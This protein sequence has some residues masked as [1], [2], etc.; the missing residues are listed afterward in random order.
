MKLT[1]DILRLV[2]QMAEFNHECWYKERTLQGWK[3]G[4]KRDEDR[5]ENPCLVPY[6]ELSEEEKK[7]NRATALE[8]LRNI[9]DLGYNMM[10][11]E[12]QAVTADTDA[13]SR[14]QEAIN[15]IRKNPKLTVADLRR[16]WEQHSPALWAEN[17]DIYRR[18]VDAALRLGEAFLAFDITAEGLLVFRNDLRLTQ[19]QALALAR[20]GA[21]RRANSM[22][23]QLRLSGHQDEETLGILARTH[24]DFFMMAT[25]PEEKRKH[26]R[27]SFDL[28]HTSY[29]RNH[30]YY[31]GI[32]AATM[33]MMAGETQIARQ[34]AQEV[35]ELCERTLENLGPESDE[36][37]WLEAT[38]AEASIILGDLTK[39]ER[40][41][42]SAT[43]GGGDK[44]AIVSR[45]RAQARLLL[46]HMTGNPN[47][48]DHCF[49]LPRIVVFSGH[50]FDRPERAQPRFPL[51]A[52]GMVRA[53]VARR[54]QE[55]EAQVGFSSLAC[56][57]DLLFAEAL[58]ERGGEVN[59][60]LPFNQRDFRKCSVD[61]IPG[62]DFGARFERVLARAA[63]VTILSEWGDATDGAPFDYC[64][65]AING[66]ALLKGKFFGMDVVPMA[67]WNGQPGDG[68][69]G[70]HSFVEYWSSRA[71]MVEIIRLDQLLAKG[72]PAPARAATTDAS[73]AGAVPDR[74]AL[75]SKQQIKAML[76][77]DVV[78]FTRLTEMQI[79]LFVDHFLGRVAGL[80]KQMPH[81]PV[82]QNTWGDAVCCVFDTV[83]D[84]GIFALQL[85]DL[86]RDTDWN[87][88]GLPGELNI[89]IALHA[90]PVYACYD[91]V[92]GKMTYN[93]AHVN[94]T[95]R[96]EPVAEEGQIYASQ[97]FAALATAEGVAEFLCDYVGTKQLAKK[98]GAIPVFLVRQTG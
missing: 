93:G 14:V 76:F 89:R 44:L 72:A 75:V 11:P 78:G 16:I 36:R 54:L 67:V 98:Y 73:A 30:G 35:M 15:E 65:R 46:E 56:G 57:G 71:P 41:Y 83:R 59:I 7:F 95:A 10:G 97:A 88:Y 92:L 52:E 58:L 42:R 62:V 40:H 45:T 12:G 3:Y 1:E 39:A 87:Q 32:N 96:I 20:T 34:T 47:L 43:V 28:Y 27:I 64:N 55:V 63:T 33:G 79:P 94:R 17:V 13:K 48:L 26:L 51:A 61:L 22:L 24:K 21:T 86:V 23:D 70:T 29:Q 49:H 18:S 77:A 82:H 84:A 90:G 66:L 69:G 8:T 50:M 74:G 2:E 60:V 38:L 5:K 68:A 31:S 53:E 91:P 6:K 80:M 4:P 19:L 25:N 37:Y 9:L 85:R 81:P